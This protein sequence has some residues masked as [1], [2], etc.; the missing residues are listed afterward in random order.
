LLD[1][2]A[3]LTDYQTGPGDFNDLILARLCE[4]RG[5]KLVTH[6]ADF[7]GTGATILTANRRLLP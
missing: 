4:H 1:L 5:L 7:A 6:D 3:I 2:G